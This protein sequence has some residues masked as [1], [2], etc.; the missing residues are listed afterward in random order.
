MNTFSEGMV[1]RDV[2]EC[3]RVEEM[4]GRTS[5]TKPLFPDD[6]RDLARFNA[7]PETE[8]LYRDLAY[9]LRE[10]ERFLSNLISKDRYNAGGS[11]DYLTT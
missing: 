3:S 4:G 8:Q 5:K 11:E 10:V 2:S 7:G 6:E 9:A 1:W